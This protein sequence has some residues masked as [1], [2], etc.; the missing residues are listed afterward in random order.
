MTTLAT[1]LALAVSLPAGQPPEIVLPAPAPLT[2][3]PAPVPTIDEFARTFIP[4]AGT[5][6]V[7]LIHPVKKCPVQVCFTLPPGCPKV[8]TGKFRLEFDYGRHSVVI[9]FKLIGG[10]YVV[11]Y[12]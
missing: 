9:R 4:I 11:N 6:E 1:W 7:V 2:A 10:K 8:R 12:V 3:I 5:Y